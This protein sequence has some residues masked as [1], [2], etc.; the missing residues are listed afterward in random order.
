MFQK[1]V[2]SGRLV[3]LLSI[4]ACL[5]ELTFFPFQWT[6][7]CSHFSFLVIF[8]VA[9]SQVWHA[10]FPATH[11]VLNGNETNLTSGSG[12]LKGPVHICSEI[13]S[14]YFL[15]YS[16]CKFWSHWRFRCEVN[17]TYDPDC[18]HER[19]YKHGVSLPPLLLLAPTLGFSVIFLTFHNPFFNYKFSTHIPSP[20][21]LH[22]EILLT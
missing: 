18:T 19:T 10:C 22:V 1:S 5:L 6:H 7:S 12:L 14:N 20:C 3:K 9:T 8:S 21:K 15:F 13:L 16:A 17:P 2:H 4:V 11:F